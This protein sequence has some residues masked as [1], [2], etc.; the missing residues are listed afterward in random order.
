MTASYAIFFTLVLTIAFGCAS[1]QVHDQNI[2]QKVLHKAIIDRTFIFG[3]W[4]ETKGTETHLTYL[5]RVTTKH[6]QTYKI[7]N[8]I[9]FWGLSH[10]ATSRILVF[11][12]ENRYVGNYYVTVTTDLPTKMESGKLIF[13]NID[14]DCDKNIATVLDLKQGLPRQFFRKCNG[15]YGDSYSLDTEF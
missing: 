4:T 7:L 9:W 3:K 8:S 11:T 15:K 5:G 12:N 6:G 10:R 13:K 1:G 14:G 2:R